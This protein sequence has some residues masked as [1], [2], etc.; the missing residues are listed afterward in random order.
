MRQ[1]SVA[2]SLGLYSM[3]ISLHLMH[4]KSPQL[5]SFPYNNFDSLLSSSSTS[6]FSRFASTVASANANFSIL[7]ATVVVSTENSL[8]LLLFQAMDLHGFVSD[9]VVV[10]FLDEFHADTTGLHRIGRL[11][12]ESFP[13][14]LIMLFCIDNYW[15]FRFLVTSS[16]ENS[17]YGY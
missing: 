12:V 10:L 2:I 17:Q 9:E 16:R 14:A 5:S 8:V 7:D 1:T 15:R 4:S 11:V 6:S 13:A 3:Q